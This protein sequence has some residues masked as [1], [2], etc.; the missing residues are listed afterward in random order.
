MPLRVALAVGEGQDLERIAVRILEV[1]GLDPAGVRVPVG[2]ALGSGRGEGDVVPAE[3]VEGPVH[4]GD[5]ERDV[6]EP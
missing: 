6:L 3:P 4:V 5:D 2:Q 1:E